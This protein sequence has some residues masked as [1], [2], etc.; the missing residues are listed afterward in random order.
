M[1]FSPN[2]VGIGDGGADDGDDDHGDA[3]FVSYPLLKMPV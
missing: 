2:G 1:F 3:F